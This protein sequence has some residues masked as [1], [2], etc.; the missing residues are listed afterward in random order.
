MIGLV[1]FDLQQSTSKTLL[2]P[3]LEIM[4]LATYYKLEE[5]QFCRLIKLD[6]TDLTGYD[7]IYFFSEL[8]REPEIPSQFL[9]AQNVNFGGTA[10][11]NGIYKP[12]E[13]ELID[14]TLARPT[15]YKEFLKDKYNEG[16]KAKVIEYL[17]DDSYYR[18]YA[19]KNKLPISPVKNNKHFFLYDRDFFYSD[20]KDTLKEIS[21]R[22][23]SQIIRIHPIICNKVSD[24]FCARSYQ[25][26][27]RTTEYILDLDI[28]LED[29]NYLIK[30]YKNQ[31]L[32][33]IVKE[34]NVYIPLKGEKY[35]KL[36]YAS[37]LVYRLNLIYS[38]WAAN[39]PVC[40]KYIY[41]KIGII[42]PYQDL[43]LM[44][45]QWCFIKRKR[46]IPK[47]FYEWIPKDKKYNYLREQIDE[48]CKYKPDIQKLFNYTFKEI[49]KKGVWYI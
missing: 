25:K 14:Y 3:N 49:N 37:E 39:I 19:G 1:D 22:K 10:F 26:L 4:K 24:F 32:A 16:I 6:E 20:W 17:L 44:I 34:S 42:N 36:Q 30:N 2:I 48:L 13:N 47:N 46:K 5:N 15:I 7:K 9:R 43:F 45:E 38:F 28:V 21:E 12:F 40:F 18:N 8:A 27:S 23:C 41:P 33:E 31:F 35:T 11:T 29:V